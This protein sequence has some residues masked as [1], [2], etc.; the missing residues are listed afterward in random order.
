MQETYHELV[1]TPS[2]HME[3]FSDFLS[4]SLPVGF[5]ETENQ[6]IVRSEEELETLAWGVE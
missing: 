3:H 2:A 6:F 5:E 1:I 4:S